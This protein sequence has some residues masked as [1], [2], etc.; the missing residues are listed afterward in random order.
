MLLLRASIPSTVEIRSDLAP[1]TKPVLANATKIHEIVMNLCTNAAQAMQER[2]VLSIVYREQTLQKSIEGVAGTIE[3]GEYS[4][5]T[6]ED[7][8][9]GIT[10]ENQRRVFEPFFTTKD[11]GEGTG[12]GLSVVFGIVQSH[13][14]DI[15][16]RSKPGH[17]TAF[18]I[19]LPKSE[20]CSQ[21]Q[22]ES[23]PTVPGGS[24]TVL[25]VDDE[26]M[27]CD[28]TKHMLESLGYDVVAF[29]DS[30]RALEV[31]GKS[32]HKYDMV[33]TDQTM[34]GITGFD[35]SREMLKIRDEIPVILC[36]GYS[37]TVDEE[38]CRAAG[39]RGFCMK[40]LQKNEL[41]RKM[42]DIFEQ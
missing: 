26:E 32:P 31:F 14:G 19:F 7:T 40:P 29:T 23:I 5:I 27:L 42:R 9:C 1:D 34:P 39:I 21:F 30:L 37:K 20:E 22:E 41:A 24:E 15:I 35:L 13:D 2:G 4:V 6:I 17:G 38:Q 18:S 36:T 25:F 12:M 8:G 11:V 3:P 33:I 10:L 28:M 16:L